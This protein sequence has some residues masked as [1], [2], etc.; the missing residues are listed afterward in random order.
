MCSLFFPQVWSWL[1]NAQHRVSESK[2]K[3]PSAD[4]SSNGPVCFRA[5]AN[6]VSKRWEELSSVDVV[7]ESIVIRRYEGGNI[8]LNAAVA[9]SRCG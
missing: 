4:L 8:S 7:D 2:V 1:E 3:P 5:W 6:Q 9:S